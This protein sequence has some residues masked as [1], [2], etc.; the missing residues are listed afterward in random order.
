MPVDDV[1]PLPIGAAWEAIS[2][3]DADALVAVCD[4]DVSFESRITAI[5][6]E[7]YAG[8]AG[9]RRYI[10]NLA[11][12]FERIELEV[13][14]L[15]EDRGRAVATNRFRARGRGGGVEVEDRFYVASKGRDGKLLWWGFFDSRSSALEA[16]ELAL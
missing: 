10:A 9:L 12:A 6:H 14:D 15:V 16:M 13:S 8:H 11:E 5:D 4:P 2:R 7:T 3:M 1:K